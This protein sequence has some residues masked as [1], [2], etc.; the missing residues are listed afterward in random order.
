MRPLLYVYGFVSA[1][2]YYFIFLSMS[3]FF[4][5]FFILEKP[6]AY[7]QFILVSTV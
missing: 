2:Y 4:V 6:K 7:H 3:F 1:F 5:V